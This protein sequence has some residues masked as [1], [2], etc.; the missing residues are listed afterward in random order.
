MA[1]IHRFV[2]GECGEVT[3]DT[4][5][6]GKHYCPKCGGVMG[7]DIGKISANGSYRRPVHSDSLAIHP[8]Q[9]AEHEQTFPNIRLDEQNRPVF[10][11]M[12]DH[13]AY[14][15]KCGFVKQTQKL[16]HKIGTERV[17]WDGV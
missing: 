13:Q 8:D 10:D 11:N 14:L 15:D 5:T 2:C 3:E 12:H 16:R 9:R 7:W 4:N 6:R 17:V 1:V